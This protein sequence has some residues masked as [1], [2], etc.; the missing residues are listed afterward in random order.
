M[1]KVRATKK[2]FSFNSTRLNMMNLRFKLSF[3]KWL[4][5]NNSN[6]YNTII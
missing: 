4:L 3:K 6:K 1:Y 2:H 5:E